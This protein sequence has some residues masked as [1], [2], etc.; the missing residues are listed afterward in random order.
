MTVITYDWN[1]DEK[2]WYARIATTVDTDGCEGLT[3]CGDSQETARENLILSVRRE[4]FQYRENA[5]KLALVL[6]EEAGRL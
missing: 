5:S 6:T 2:N 1:E 4:M 3:G